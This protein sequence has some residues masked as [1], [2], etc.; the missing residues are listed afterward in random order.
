MIRIVRCILQVI[1]FPHNANEERIFVT[2][3]NRS[4]QVKFIIVVSS[5]ARI[6]GELKEIWEREILDIK[7]YLITLNQR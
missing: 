1:P 2:S 3:T 5:C 7:N 4:S 6:I